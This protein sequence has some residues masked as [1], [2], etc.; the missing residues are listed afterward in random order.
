MAAKCYW[1]RLQKKIDN[2]Q[3]LRKK[4]F[5]WESKEQFQVYKILV[6]LSN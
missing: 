2:Q 6:Y 4:F 3:Q 1:R 5:S